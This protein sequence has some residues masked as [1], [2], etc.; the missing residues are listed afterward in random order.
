MSGGDVQLWVARGGSEMECV[1]N[2]ESPRPLVKPTTEEE[3]ARA[4][5]EAEA[6]FCPEIWV[7]D[8]V[9]DGGLRI[10]RGPGGE[11]L[12]GSFDVNVKSPNEVGIEP[13]PTPN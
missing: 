5:E 7:G 11:P 10:K 3:E 4:E 13:P 8:E 9:K 2:L 1:R 6:G 12:R